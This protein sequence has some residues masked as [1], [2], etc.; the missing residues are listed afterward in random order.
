MGIILSFLAKPLDKHGI[1][2]AHI[3]YL[4][5]V[6][7]GIFRPLVLNIDL[8]WDIESFIALPSF[9]SCL[10]VNKVKFML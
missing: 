1:T 3:T 2:L 6:S 5:L 9:Y 8:S 10:K 7:I 4:P